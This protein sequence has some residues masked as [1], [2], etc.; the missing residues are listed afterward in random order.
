MSHSILAGDR[1][2]G[3]LA[4]WGGVLAV[5]LGVAAHLPGAVDA[6][7]HGGVPMCSAGAMDGIF[8]APMDVMM[9]I[10]MALIVGG[11]IAAG[12][13]LL[14]KASGQAAR[15]AKRVISS[16]QGNMT[17]AHWELALVL[18]IAV[19]IDVMK[20]ATLG[21]V[22][23]G[24]AREYGLSRPQVAL[25]PF[26]A[27]TGTAVGS[28]IWGLLADRFGRRATILLAAILFV[29]T[30]ICGA[31]PSF[32]WNLVMCFLM[33]LPAGGMLPI[34]FTLLSEVAPARHRGWLLV[35]LGGLALAGGYLA[36]SGAATVLEPIYGWRVLWLLGLPTGLALIALNTRIPELPSFLLLHGRTDEFN[37]VMARFNL[38]PARDADAP[39][40]SAE[41]DRPSG[42][43]R[44]FGPPMLNMSI[45]LNLMAVIWGLVNFG[46]LLWMP[47]E[48]QARGLGMA[49]ANALLAKSSLYA[50]PISVV[51]AALYQ[52]WGGKRLLVLL[53]LVTAL[54]LCLLGAWDQAGSWIGASPIQLIA[55]VMIGSNG[56][57]AVMLPYCA[58]SYPSVIRGQAT[59]FVAGASKF[60]GIGAQIATLAGAVPAVAAAALVLA[61]PMAFSALLVA[62]YGRR[63][64]A[65]EGP[66]TAFP[67]GGLDAAIGEA[68]AA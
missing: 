58:E 53:A 60:G 61:V 36:A 62:R 51:A 35:M 54:G 19:I 2:F 40:L 30:S 42:K 3:P 6:A 22:M 8:G 59:G 25:L 17:R 31:M 24:M 46:L 11:T 18:I 9:L 64:D 20:P 47:T 5:A 7:H 65:G 4:F 67:G 32:G 26:V 38:T 27:L 48:L 33:G 50:L 66:R 13:G 41:F 68:R 49:E 37:R 34:A 39:S 15:P 16:F 45:A 44:V 14:P 28:C 57:I 29:G 56:M 63:T 12:Y 21:F 23:P 55:L 10:G 1:R 52:W 43:P